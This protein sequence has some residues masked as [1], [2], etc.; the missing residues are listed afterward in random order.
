MLGRI[1]A[2]A[3]V[4]FA[5][6]C[7]AGAGGSGGVPAEEVEIVSGAEVLEYTNIHT[8]LRELRPSWVRRAREVFIDREFAGDINLL[9][10]SFS[11]EIR[12]IEL[13]PA[14]DVVRTFGP[15]QAPDGT[16]VIDTPRDPQCGTRPVIHIVRYRP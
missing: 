11:D 12:Y 8:A 1:V 7:A 5:G 14:R 15:C 6:A 9:R 3:I 10:R 4:V 13:V 16:G 2:L